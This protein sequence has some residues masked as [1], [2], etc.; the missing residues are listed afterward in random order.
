MGRTDNKFVAY[1]RHY[2]PFGGTFVIIFTLISPMLYRN[3]YTNLSIIINF[4]VTMLI[5]TFIGGAIRIGVL[6]P[7]HNKYHYSIS[8]SL[9]MLTT[10][11]GSFLVVHPVGT[12]LDKVPWF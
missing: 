7:C 10:Y 4:E 1:S 3:A 9:K 11:D 2:L 8:L 12:S 5:Y 6:T